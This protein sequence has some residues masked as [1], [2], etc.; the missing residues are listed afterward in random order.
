MLQR[1][2]AA[3]QA[4]NSS[5]DWLLATLGRLN[6]K[7]VRAALMGNSLLEKLRPILL[8]SQGENWLAKDNF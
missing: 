7:K 4:R 3:A 1:L 2:V 8:L 6:P 5:N